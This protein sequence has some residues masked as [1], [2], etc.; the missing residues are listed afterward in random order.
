MAQGA[1]ILLVFAFMMCLSCLSSS[2][3]G[4]GIFYACSDGTMSPDEFD[5]KKCTNFGVSAIL[6]GTEAIT[7]LD[8]GSEEEFEPIDTTSEEGD[9]LVPASLAD[10]ED[11]N[12][13]YYNFFGTGKSQNLSGLG[14]IAASATSKTDCARICYE[15]EVPMRGGSDECN[16]FVSDGFTKCI[17]YPSTATVSGS[18]LPSGEKSYALKV[19]RTGLAFNNFTIKNYDTPSSPKGG[20]KQY[21]NKHDVSCRDGTT[22][23][24][25]TSF[26]WRNSG[27]TTKNIYGCLMGDFGSNKS[28]VNTPSSGSGSGHKCNKDN[29]EFNYLSAGGSGGVG[30]VDCGDNFINRWKL[31]QSG[32]S[33]NIEFNCTGSETSDQSG[34]VDLETGTPDVRACNTGELTG[35]N[36][37]C[38][39][40][41]A[42]TKFQWVGGSKINYRCCPKPSSSIPS[43]SMTRSNTATTATAAADVAASSGIITGCKRLSGKYSSDEGCLRTWRQ[44]GTCGENGYCQPTYG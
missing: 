16:G 28:Q 19:N 18:S 21:G 13:T 20:P 12:E 27:N 9:L 40:N 25:L 35:T 37:R 36:V 39:A 23:G 24:A 34:C 7:G 11:P 6:E 10:E 4:S 8:V 5:F 31:K 22:N 2:A 17:L 42:L 30:D 32:N 15:N 38:P 43:R 29:N 1:I 41:T 14:V 33:M 26:T 44:L 3:A